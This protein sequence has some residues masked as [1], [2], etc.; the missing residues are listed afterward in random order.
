VFQLTPPSLR[1]IHAFVARQR[2]AALSYAEVGATRDA[3]APAGYTV[4][5]NRVRVGTGAEAF[6]DAVD[7]LR[8]WRMTALGWASVHPAGAPITPGETV[9]VVVGH[10][11]FWSLNAC[12]IVHVLDDETADVR[13]WGFAYGTLPE[14]GAV[15]EERFAVEWHRA[16]DGVWY[17][18]LAYSRPRHALMRLGYPLARRLQRRFAQASK[19]A[20]VHAVAHARADRASRRA[21][22]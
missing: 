15:G 14:H 13:R 19:Q 12:R 22:E 16:D 8:A 11:G 7:A 21:V 9:A 1:Q 20:M 6:R 4:D 10:Y 2:D 3:R 17:D 18:L 5:H